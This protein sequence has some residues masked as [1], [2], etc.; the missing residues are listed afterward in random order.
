[1][2]QAWLISGI[3]GIGKTTLAYH[4]ANYIF[5]DGKNPIGK[6]NAEQPAARL[7]AAEAHPDLFVLRRTIDE[8]TGE[9][10]AT[11]AVEEARKLAP[12]LHLTSTQGGWRIAIIDEAQALNRHGQNALLK[13]IEE[14]PA[15]CLIL[16]TV[17]T[18]GILLPTIR[19]R[20]RVLQ[21][22][23]LADSAMRAILGRACEDGEVDERR[24]QLSGGSVGMAL[25][26]LETECLP[27]Y[28][29]MTAILASMPQ[30]DMA[31]LHA[32]ADKMSR[33]ADAES[34]AVLSELLVNELQKQAK[35]AAMD[36]E[37]GGQLDRACQVWEKVGQIFIAANQ[38][39]LDRKL[40]FVNAM[41]EI[42]KS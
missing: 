18:P 29:E 26:I 17:T 16:I 40:A 10:K 32:L 33:K 38:S 8:K 13:V 42:K 34:F 25:K 23:P 31:R 3:S 30:L 36:G 20:C 41:M 35:T 24:V 15:R 14:P 28:V 5:S 9:P 12:F 37:G 22:Q 11:I 6:L 4:I 39:N 7:I 1:M 27:L 19:S 2:P 21:L